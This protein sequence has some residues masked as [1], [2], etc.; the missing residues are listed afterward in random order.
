MA[1]DSLGTTVWPATYTPFGGV[2]S[3]NVNT[4]ALSTQDLRFPGQ[5][6][7]AETGLHQNW[8]RDY[9]PTLGRYLQADPLGLIDGPAIYGY[10]L[11]NPSRYVDP[12]G[13]ELAIPGGVGGSVGE[14]TTAL[15]NLRKAV[16]IGAAGAAA[17]STPIGACVLAILLVDLAT[18]APACGCEDDDYCWKQYERDLDGCKTQYASCLAIAGAAR[19]SKLITQCQRQ[20]ALCESD[21]LKEYNSCRGL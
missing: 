10:A 11:Q 12:H 6:F 2:H 3:V 1:T 14:A 16:R 8:H 18:A 4:G 21:A 17:A 9:D 20:F 7:Q 15:N 5:W 19:K 13:L